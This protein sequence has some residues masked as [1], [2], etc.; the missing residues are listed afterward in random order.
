MKTVFE[1]ES[2]GKCHGCS[3]A[4][5]H[6]YLSAIGI[7]TPTAT[8][9]AFLPRNTRLSWVFI[10]IHWRSKVHLNPDLYFCISSKQKTVRLALI[11]WI[12][13]LTSWGSYIQASD[14]Y[15]VPPSFQQIRVIQTYFSELWPVP[16]ESTPCCRSKEKK[17]ICLMNK[18]TNHSCC[19]C[20]LHCCKAL[21]EGTVCRSTH[22]M[23]KVLSSFDAAV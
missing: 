9:T 2:N 8:G 5:T 7:S 6:L 18:Q 17:H 16:T 15:S 12:L 3:T 23:S 21:T 10:S 19:C 13:A 14:E 1:K 4:G 22:L 11:L 20:G